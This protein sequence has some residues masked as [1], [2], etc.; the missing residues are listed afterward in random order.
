V[1]VL[2]LQEAEAENFFKSFFFLFIIYNLNKKKQKKIILF[3]PLF[4]LTSTR[5]FGLIIFVK[6]FHF[7]NKNINA[8]INSDRKIV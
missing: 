8:I 5:L 7:M 6:Y 1:R 3:L 4:L 2:R